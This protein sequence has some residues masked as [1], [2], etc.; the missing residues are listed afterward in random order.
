[1]TPLCLDKA[2]LTAPLP[3]VNETDADKQGENYTGLAA[4]SKDRS[5]SSDDRPLKKPVFDWAVAEKVINRI[6]SLL[7]TD[8]DRVGTILK[9]CG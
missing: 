5:G 3:R 6:F 4:K 8:R 7:S 2:C 9:S 1:M